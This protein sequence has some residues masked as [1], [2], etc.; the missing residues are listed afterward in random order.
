MPHHFASHKVK[1]ITFVKD[2]Q[3]PFVL[4]GDA[5]SKK[6]AIHRPEVINFALIVLTQMGTNSTM[7]EAGFLFVGFNDEGRQPLAAFRAAFL[8]NFQKPVFNPPPPNAHVG[9]RF[10]INCQL[11][12]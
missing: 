11:H 9:Q 3:K 12:C 10:E 8:A 1:S 4:E 6:L 2:P 7:R 5:K